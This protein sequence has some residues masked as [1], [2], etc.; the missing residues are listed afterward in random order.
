MRKIQLSVLCLLISLQG[1]FAQ[2]PGGATV[3]VPVAEIIKQ[4]VVRVIRAVDLKIQRLQNE[5]I[6]LQHAQKEMEN[7]LSKLKL[8]EIAG[9]VGKQKSLY[10]EYFDELWRVRNAVAYYHRVKDITAKQLQ[11]VKAYQQ[12]K[13]FLKDGRHFTVD[14]ISHMSLLYE[15]LLEQSISN[16]DQLFIV[17]NAFTTQMSDRSRLAIIDNVAAAVD[18]LYADILHF[19]QQNQLL[20]LQ[21]VKDARDADQVKE[22]YGVE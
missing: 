3:P 9:W 1:V 14:E 21:R 18:D 7:A 13:Q 20:R 6:W 17:V 16:V 19:N 12:A 10:E 2:V 5:T 11:L 15:Q 4:A 22:L 8:E